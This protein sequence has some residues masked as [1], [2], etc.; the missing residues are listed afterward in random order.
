MCCLMCSATPDF[1]IKLHHKRKRTPSNFLE[2]VLVK[3]LISPDSTK[4]VLIGPDLVSQLL[5][6]CCQNDGEG[7]KTRIV[8]RFNPSMIS[9]LEAVFS[10]FTKP[11][12]SCQNPVI[13]RLRATSTFSIT[14]HKFP[15]I[16]FQMV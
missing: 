14:F 3:H 6:N 12:I 8:M 1:K 5:S 2:S 15:Y 7:S 9:L 4:S 11:V 13:I 10:G 16:V